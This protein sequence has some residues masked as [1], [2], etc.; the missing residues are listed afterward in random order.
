MADTER[1]TIG[2]EE[3][4]ISTETGSGRK[5]YSGT[6]INDDDM[7]YVDIGG[8]IWG[9]QEQGHWVIKGTDIECFD[10]YTRSYVRSEEART[11]AEIRQC[12]ETV[13]NIFSFKW[14][15]RR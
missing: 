5:T 10:P 8:R 15:K 14:L 3:K 9:N 4:V 6:D 12:I 2:G 13:K 1:V 11:S 7:E